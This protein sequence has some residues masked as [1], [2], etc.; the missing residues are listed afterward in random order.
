[1]LEVNKHLNSKRKSF[2][3]I[4]LIIKSH[5]IWVRKKVKENFMINPNKYIQ[6]FL[7]MVCRFSIWSRGLVQ[8]LFSQISSLLNL[9]SFYCLFILI[10][11]TNFFAV[12]FNCYWTMAF[13]TIIKLITQILLLTFEKIILWHGMRWPWDEMTWS[14]ISGGGIFIVWS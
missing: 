10:I 1:M 6:P 2:I 13:I 8:F 9:L 4:M 14:L 7:L 11:F 5:K 12:S 3:Q